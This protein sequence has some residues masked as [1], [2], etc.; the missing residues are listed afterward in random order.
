MTSTPSR[1]VLAPSGSLPRWW[2]E[3]EQMTR[4]Q[5][6][7]PAPLMRSAPRPSPVLFQWVTTSRAQPACWQT[8]WMAWRTAPMSYRFDPLAP[9]A[10]RYS[11]SSTT[12]T[13]GCAWSSCLDGGQ[14][15]AG[16]G[17]GQAGHAEAEP[18]LIGQLVGVD[19][20]AGGDGL[21]AADGGP[22]PAFAEEDQDGA[23]VGAGEVVE[24]GPSGG[25]R[26]GEVEGGPGLAGLLLGGQDPVGI[27]GP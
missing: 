22:L 17:G 18:E 24:P 12:R 1:T 20:F 10:A 19:G 14:L 26:D 16:A 11:G 5:A 23:G 25:D 15:A 7:G 27:G 6:A 13:A 4:A 2:I 8:P 3:T 9:A 21:D